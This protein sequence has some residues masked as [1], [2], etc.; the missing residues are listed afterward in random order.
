M[1]LLLAG[2][3]SGVLSS[4]LTLLSLDILVTFSILTFGTSAKRPVS[5]FDTV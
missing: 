2:R 3:S 4:L 1:I 5:T